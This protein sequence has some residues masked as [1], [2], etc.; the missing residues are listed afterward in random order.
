MFFYFLF[1]LWPTKKLKYEWPQ[2]LFFF[3]IIIKS[4]ILIYKKFYL[5]AL[6]ELFKRTIKIIKYLIKEKI[7]EP[8]TRYDILRHSITYINLIILR[9]KIFNNYRFATCT[10]G[11]STLRWI[12]NLRTPIVTNKWPC[13]NQQKPTWT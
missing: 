3:L 1:K 4:I 10:H 8:L 9:W 7:Y 12:S 2:F 5:H 11:W 6:K 13:K